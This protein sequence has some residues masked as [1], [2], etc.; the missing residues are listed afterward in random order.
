MHCARVVLD[1]SLTGLRRVEDLWGHIKLP[2]L[3]HLSLFADKDGWKDTISA[4]SIYTSLIG[5]PWDGWKALRYPHQAGNFT[6]EAQ[7]VVLSCP[8]LRY[9]SCG[10]DIN[11]AV[12]Q[13]ITANWGVENRLVT[14]TTSRYCRAPFILATR[15]QMHGRH[16]RNHSLPARNIIWQSNG[17][18]D[19][20][21]ALC[22]HALSH[23]EASITCIG[24]S[25]ALDCRVPY[26]RPSQRP[27]QPSN[28][29]PF[30]Y[31]NTIK[32]FFDKRPEMLSA[33][34]PDG[35]P[36]HDH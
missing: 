7:Y 18:Q 28:Y 8:I 31:A 2:L 4:N 27:L 22:S 11:G 6:I 32:D 34:L 13:T 24:P 25:E 29:T 36:W 17:I 1:G 10:G 35:I 21:Q 14:N 33:S 5:V 16:E 3:S 26:M 15:T 30:E 9:I 23:V 12:Y 20:K 19:C